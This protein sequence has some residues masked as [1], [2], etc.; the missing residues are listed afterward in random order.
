MLPPGSQGSQGDHSTLNTWSDMGRSGTSN[1]IQGCCEENYHQEGKSQLSPAHPHSPPVFWFPVLAKVQGVYHLA[2]SPAKK[3]DLSVSGPHSLRCV[4]QSPPKMYIHLDPQNESLFGNRVFA[5][6]IKLRWG[7]H[8]FGWTLNPTDVPRRSR[9]IETRPV[10][11][12]SSH[13]A[14]I[15]RPKKKKRKEKKGETHTN[16]HLRNEMILSVG[17][18]WEGG[19]EF[20]TQ[21][22]RFPL[23][24]SSFV[25]GNW[26]EFLQIN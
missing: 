26:H 11:R 23:F 10:G 1:A 17:S 24:F 9:E 6:A 3:T 22:D 18:C 2:K 14:E 20:E 5:D 25:M 7:Y 16:T 21:S 12:Q 15:V 19:V 4:I 8:G 13:L